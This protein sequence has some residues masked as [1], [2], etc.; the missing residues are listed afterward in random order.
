MMPASAPAPSQLEQAIEQAW[1]R[2]PHELARPQVENALSPALPA[3][4]IDRLLATPR[5]EQRLA[6]RIAGRLGLVRPSADDFADPPTRIVLAGRPAVEKAI[7]LSGAILH[8]ARIRPLVLRSQR[9]EISAAI[10]ADAFAAAQSCRVE[11]PPP[12]EVWAPAQLIAAC[13]R[14]GPT[15]MASWMRGLPQGV[16]SWLTAFVPSLADLDVAE[17]PEREAIAAA[18]LAAASVLASSHG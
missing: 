16:A 14:D 4:L 3:D 11:T 5:I 17:F 10:G 13:L 1:R 18:G 12:G 6:D 15:C 7:R 9:A 8:R 2:L